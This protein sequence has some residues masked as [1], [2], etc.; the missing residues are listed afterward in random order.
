M[1]P[2]LK[3]TLA[4]IAV[5]VSLP[6]FAQEAPKPAT[7]ANAPDQPT[8][9]VGKLQRPYLYAH[10]GAS[11]LR[12]EHSRAGYWLAMEQGADFIEPDLRTTKDG[13]LVALHDDSLNRTTNV[14]ELPEFDVLAKVNAKD[15]KKYWYP[16]DFTL[17]QLKTLKTRGPAKMPQEFQLVDPIPTLEEVI[18]WAREYRTK[19][20]RTVGIIPEIRGSEALFVATIKRLQVEEG[21]EAIPMIVQSFGLGSL[22]KVRKEIKSPLAWLVN[23]RIPKAEYDPLKGIIDELSIVRGKLDKD[24]GTAWIAE[25]HA[26]GFT[27]SAWTYDD[28]KDTKDLVATL[29][30]GLDGFFTNYPNLG[31]Q[32]R[33][34][35]RQ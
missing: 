15:G 10:R 14:A 17:A 20:G 9:P 21:A 27:V 26:A 25:I 7:P 32:A 8:V 5:A 30:K 24:E 22:K 2:K 35:A 18:G 12:P 33:Q 31:V 29:R 1:M 19:T 34:A 3:F 11:G 6:L 28:E 16:G 13:V 23:D 4:A